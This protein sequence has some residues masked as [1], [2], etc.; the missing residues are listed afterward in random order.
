MIILV[1]HYFVRATN[2]HIHLVALLVKHI[3]QI[4]TQVV[5]MIN[6]TELKMFSMFSMH[7]FMQQKTRAYFRGFQLASNFLN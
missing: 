7:M 4:R 5:T 3:Y 1:F 6:K 2:A